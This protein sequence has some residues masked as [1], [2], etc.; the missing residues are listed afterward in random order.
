MPDILTA[1]TEAAVALYRTRAEAAGA[2]QA[3]PGLFADM[4]PVL[5]EAQRVSSIAALQKERL[6]SLLALASTD[7]QLREIL[8]APPGALDPMVIHPGGG[9]RMPPAAMILGLFSSAFFE[10]YCLR[11]PDQESTFVRTVLDNF[12]ELRRAARGERVR[13]YSFTGIALVTMPDGT[14][15]STPWGTLRPAPVAQDLNIFLLSRPGTKCI[16]AEEKL[17]PV[18]FDRAAEPKPSFDASDLTPSRSGALLPLACALARNG[19]EPLAVPLPTWS[20]LFVPFQA[21]AFSYSL[22]PIGIQFPRSEIDIGNRLAAIEEW[23]RIVDR[24]HAPAV[25][26]A[27][28]RLV[29]AAAHR[30]DRSDALIDAVTVWENLLGTHSEVTFRV[31][32]ALAKMLEKD[33]AK[34]RTLRGDLAEIYDIRSRIIHGAAVDASAINDA[35]SKAIDVAAKALQISYAKGTEWLSLKSRDRCDAVLLEWP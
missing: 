17:I 12:E 35:C 13:A 3:W 14:Q 23:S 30:A 1:L 20:T 28:R 16:L 24:A 21:G 6:D 32:A 10:M 19:S 25:D 2:L 26:I 11:L 34:R 33:P 7:P 29:S 31:T 8:T 4:D 22:T 5:T 18:R 27:G 15:V 9:I